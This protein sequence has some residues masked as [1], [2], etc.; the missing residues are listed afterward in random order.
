MGFQALKEWDRDL[1]TKEKNKGENL[2]EKLRAK[3]VEKYISG[4]EFKF[5]WVQYTASSL[6]E[7]VPHSSDAFATNPKYPSPRRDSSATW[8]TLL[9][10]DGLHTTTV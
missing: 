4:I 10:P 5:C 7:C 1:E 3:T 8:M 9:L 2:M 6:K